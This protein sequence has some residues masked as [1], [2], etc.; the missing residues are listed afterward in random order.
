MKLNFMWRVF[1]FVPAML[2]M[3]AG[4]AS[5]QYIFPNG[6]IWGPGADFIRPG[7]PSTFEKLVYSRQATRKMYDRRVDRW[8]SNRAYVFKAHFS[9]QKPMEI[10]VHS[11]FGS[12][13][14]AYRE[15]QRYTRELGQLPRLLRSRVKTLSV[16]PGNELYGGGNDNIHVSSERTNEYLARGN[17]AEVLFH[18]AAHASLDPKYAKSSAWKQAQRNDIASISKYAAENPQREDIAEM[19]L[20]AYTLI[21][22]PD[23]VPTSMRNRIEKTMPN[24]MAFFRGVFK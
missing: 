19:S 24:R 18:E 12:V 17:L 13:E 9:D 14:N 8:I 22:H 11:D 16:L 21:Y 6:T 20:V 23:R 15:A 4:S 5:G 10:H 2:V 3:L 7:D 1:A